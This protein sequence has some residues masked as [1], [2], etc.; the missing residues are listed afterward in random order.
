MAGLILF[1]DL[2]EVFGYNDPIEIRH[3][4]ESVRFI[5]H[6]HPH[7]P[8]NYGF[9]TME[10]VSAATIINPQ[11]KRVVCLAVSTNVQK[12]HGNPSS[13]SATIDILSF[14]EMYWPAEGLF[15]VSAGNLSDEERANYPL[16]NDDSCVNDPGQAFNAL[17]VG[18]YSLKDAISM[19]HNLHEM[20]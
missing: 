10:A 9:V 5:D 2:T 19:Q 1:G 7:D 13:W 8:Q 14:G 17:T 20:G 16:S 3:H 12:N 4:L 11:N 15:V 18:A 6:N